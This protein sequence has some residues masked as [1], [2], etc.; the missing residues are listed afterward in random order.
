MRPKL[1]RQMIVACFGVL[2]LGAHSAV[3]QVASSPESVTP[4]QIGAEVPEVSVRNLEGEQSPLSTVLKGQAS[5]L[6]FYRGG[7]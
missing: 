1:P 2:V 4:L 3:A 5:L 6:V 7:W